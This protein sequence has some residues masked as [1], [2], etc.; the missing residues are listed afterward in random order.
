[1]WVLHGA[2]ALLSEQR[3]MLEKAGSIRSF[4][5]YQ[6]LSPEALTPQLQ[7]LSC[8]QP[9]HPGIL[10]SPTCCALVSTYIRL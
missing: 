3:E 8:L 1:M 6:K 10:I 2:A 7:K 5:L 9:G 4:S